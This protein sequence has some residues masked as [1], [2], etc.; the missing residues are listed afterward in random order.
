MCLKTDKMLLFKICMYKNQKKIFKQG[1]FSQHHLTKLSMG[2]N[3]LKGSGVEKWGL[4]LQCEW[5]LRPGKVEGEENV[6]E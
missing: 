2:P 5:D 3:H 6:N 4:W 1:L